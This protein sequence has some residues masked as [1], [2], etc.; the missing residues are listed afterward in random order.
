MN[1]DSFL[2]KSLEDIGKMKHKE[3]LNAKGENLYSKCYS[4]FESNKIE[5]TIISNL[6]MKQSENTRQMDE[7]KRSL[8]NNIQRHSKMCR[9]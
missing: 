7:L 3:N 5:I 1:E 6:R 4:N 8:I 9:W 2:A